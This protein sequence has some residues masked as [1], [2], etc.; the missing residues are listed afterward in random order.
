MEVPLVYKLNTVRPKSD[1]LSRLS[2]STVLG[3]SR[4]LNALFKDVCTFKKAMFVE[5][6]FTGFMASDISLTNAM[7]KNAIHI[8][9][10]I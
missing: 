4:E 1:I 10:T 2:N 5:P 9:S 8:F 3:Y 7:T 6:M